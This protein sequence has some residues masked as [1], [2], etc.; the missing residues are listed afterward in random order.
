MLED[1]RAYN[2]LFD[3]VERKKLVAQ[4]LRQLREA[5]NYSKANVADYI[6]VKLSTYTAYE[7][8]RNEPPI[9]I[10]VRLSKLYSTPIDIIVQSANTS[11]GLLEA[12]SQINVYEEQIK[13]MKKKI[14][15]GDGSDEALKPFIESLEKLSDLMK[16]AIEVQKK[17]CN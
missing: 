5:N 13:E 1:L 9:E 8:G 6:G 4:S 12:E 17:N 16:Q 15:S 3:Y 11:K 14:A 7:S 2:N 10:L